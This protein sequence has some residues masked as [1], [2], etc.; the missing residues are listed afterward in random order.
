MKINIFLLIAV[1]ASFFSCQVE[2]RASKVEVQV[3]PLDVVIHGPYKPDQFRELKETIWFRAPT[4]V[5]A[6]DIFS[7]EDFYILELL[8]L[9]PDTLYVH[10]DG[11]IG[12]ILYDNFCFY[13]ID[14]KYLAPGHGG[15]I[16]CHFDTERDTILPNASKRYLTNIYYFIEEDNCS[17]MYL[18]LD[19]KSAFFDS[20]NHYHPF[21]YYFFSAGPIVINH[22]AFLFDIVDGRAIPAAPINLQKELDKTE[23]MLKKK[24]KRQG[25]R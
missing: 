17:K 3:Y 24:N 2:K 7:K 5:D 4:F 15:S 6:V 8:N 20:L 23:A 19:I 14:E 16:K 11:G 18:S 22:P 12:F 10:N 25:G 9:S 21:Q 1:L 13:H